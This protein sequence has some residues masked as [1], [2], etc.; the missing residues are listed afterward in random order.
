MTRLHWVMCVVLSGMAAGAAEEPLSDSPSQ[1]SEEAWPMA[2]GC[3][4][5]SGRSS[6]ILRLP[7]IE[8]WRRS[9]DETA[10]EATPV[11]ADGTCFLGDLDGGFHAISLESGETVW[12]SRRDGQKGL[13][14]FP[15]SAA[16]ANGADGVPIVV[17]GDADGL[18]RA[19]DRRTGAIIWT[20][21]REGEISGGPTVFG[22]ETGDR[23]LIGSQ[24]ATLVRL[25]ARTG[26]PDWEIKLADQIRSS[27][28]VA[29]GR[30][31]IAGCDGRLHVIDVAS[32]RELAAVPIDGP[33]GTTPAAVG[34]L[35]CFGSEGGIFWGIDATAGDVR[36]KSTATP[37]GPSYRSSAAIG[38][39][40][41]R[42]LAIVGSRGRAVEAFLIADGSL[43]W[44]IPMRGR[45]DGSP[46]IVRVV[47]D[48][49]DKEPIEA[50][51]V[52]DAAGIV[53]IL[54]CADGEVL[55]EW[56]AGG[57]FTASAAIAGGRVLLP[58]DDGNVWCFRSSP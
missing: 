38:G 43:S 30:A 47:R 53:R 33:T 28:T 7:L 17:A 1:T 18:I 3:L 27:P 10:F 44:R 35:A 32:G 36:W 9:F 45:V 48:G 51:V 21:E 16:I 56:D 34:P 19:F 29:A 49:I 22:T 25:D 20:H 54:R 39:T 31:L 46:V 15:A 57:G 5:G 13:A 52:A 2:R 55:W 26:R 8:A 6:T 24:D 40:E 58:A 37:G 4:D 50:A 23:L 14:G 11:I 42:W 12:S 41:G